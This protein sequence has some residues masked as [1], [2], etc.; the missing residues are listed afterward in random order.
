MMLNM[1][2]R[3]DSA[4]RSNTASELLKLKVAVLECLE[5]GID[6]KRGKRR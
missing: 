1:E 5:G 6:R 4:V 3:Q 2:H